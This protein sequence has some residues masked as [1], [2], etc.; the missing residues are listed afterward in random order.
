MPANTCAKVNTATWQRPAV[1]DGLQT[2]GNVDFVEMHRTFNC[3]IGMVLVIDPKDQ[4]QA[5]E[6]LQALGEQVSVIGEINA[7]DKVEPFV[8]LVTE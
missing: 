8:E 3:G 1:F 6:L 2:H 4:A 7:T 5:I